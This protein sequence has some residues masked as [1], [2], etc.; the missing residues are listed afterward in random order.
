ME[1]S[2]NKSKHVV[3]QNLYFI[4]K[5]IFDALLKKIPERS[6]ADE[7]SCN[8]CCPCCGCTCYDEKDKKFTIDFS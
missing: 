5:A 2:T 4:S 3:L 7:H 6:E 8:V 1:N